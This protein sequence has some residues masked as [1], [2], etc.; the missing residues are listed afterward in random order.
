MC[1]AL[2]PVYSLSSWNIMTT[3]NSVLVCFC[4]FFGISGARS[5][6]NILARLYVCCGV[7][8]VGRAVFIVYLAL[9]FGSCCYCCHKVNSG[10]WFVLHNFALNLIIIIKA[11]MPAFETCSM[12]LCTMYT[13]GSWWTFLPPFLGFNVFSTEWCEQQNLLFDWLGW[14][15]WLAY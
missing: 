2:C 10:G 8:R 14:G 3:L 9:F 1:V 4:V 15:S 6:S 11:C 12:Q 5:R 13:L 7:S